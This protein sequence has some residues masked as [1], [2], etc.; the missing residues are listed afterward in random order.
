MLHM[1][2]AR[3][4]LSS[5]LK[6]LLVT[7]ACAL[8][9]LAG[10]SS[11][12]QA[13]PLAGGLSSA[14]S[15]PPPT[16]TITG[17]SP[18]PDFSGS[19]PT[20]ITCNVS[21]ANPHNSGHVGGTVNFVASTSCDAP[22]SSIVQTITLFWDGYLQSSKSQSNSGEASLSGNVAAACT[23]G[24]WQGSVTTTVVF[25]PGYVPP[26]DTGSASNVQEITC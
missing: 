11:S 4:I 10:L 25:P 22:V 13:A 20:L 6:A 8:A 3:K 17:T 23:S 18:T 19:G 5:H 16:I 12:A 14:Q 1:G 7:G 15:D 9:L 26:S 24:G 2:H 21:A